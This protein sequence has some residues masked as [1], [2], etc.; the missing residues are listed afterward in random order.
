MGDR[1]TITRQE[2]R[3]VI[4]GHE[5]KLDGKPA[6]SSAVVAGDTI[7]LAGATSG[8]DA[9]GNVVGRGDIEAQTIAVFES[10]KSTLAATHAT[11]ADLT[12]ITVLATK[13]EYRAKIGEGP[14][15]LHPPAAARE[16]VHGREQPRRPRVSR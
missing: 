3:H 13:L 4:T 8:R 5:S 6:Y 1:R 16:H 9:A 2:P 14:I 15:A 12:K 11:F 10:L 7:Y